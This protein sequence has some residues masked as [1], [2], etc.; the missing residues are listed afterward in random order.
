MQRLL[1][2]AVLALPLAAQPPRGVTNWWDTPM[3]R[4]LNLS[5]DQ[6]RQIR[7]VAREFRSRLMEHRAALERAESDLETAFNDE[8]FDQKR[9]NEA[10]E[11]LITARGDLTRD[12][13]QMSMRMRALLNVEQFR[14]LQRRRPRMFSPPGMRGPGGERRQMQRPPAPPPQE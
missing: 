9:A 8:S 4:D 12:V 1:W 5:E 14:E 11:R 6:T 3:A 7:S 10:L 2:I 13:T